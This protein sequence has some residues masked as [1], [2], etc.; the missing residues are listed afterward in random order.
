MTPAA[1]KAAPIPAEVL[2][3]AEAHSGFS[4]AHAWNPETLGGGANLTIARA[5]LA[6]RASQE[7]RTAAALEAEASEGERV[8]EALRSALAL[9]DDYLAYRHDGDPWSEDARLMGEMEINCAAKDGRLDAIRA[10][11]PEAPVREGE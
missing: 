4:G 7:E 3:L 8:R 9:I 1:E 5:I 6:D 11:I 2:A 10:L